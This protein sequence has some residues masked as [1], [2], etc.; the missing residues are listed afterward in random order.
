MSEPQV[1]VILRRKS[2][3]VE[4]A[5]AA[6]K[7]KVAEAERDFAAIVAAISLFELGADTANMKPWADLSR[8]WKRGEIVTVCRAALEAEGP[9]DTRG[10]AVCVTR[11]KGRSQRRRRLRLLDPL[12]DILLD[13]QAYGNAEKHVA[14]DLQ[15]I[16]AEVQ[17]LRAEVATLK[18][19]AEKAEPITAPTPTPSSTH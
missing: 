8:L 16:T 13:W 12:A 6:Y 2:D 11:L 19:E 4:N 14:I 17:R 5:I 1:L 3:E 18:A 9:L 10:L 7:A 15:A